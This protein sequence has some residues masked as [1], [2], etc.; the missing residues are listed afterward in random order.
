MHPVQLAQARIRA[1]ERVLAAIRAQPCR[2]PGVDAE[3]AWLGRA[4]VLVD[5]VAQEEVEV[6]RLGGGVRV[7]RAPARLIVL[8]GR[9]GDPQWAGRRSRRAG[10]RAADRRDAGA[11]LPQ[12]E[13]LRVGPEPPDPGLERVVDA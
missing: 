8:A 2:I 6:E 9:E 11:A 4:A 3:V 1:R 10:A 7:R 5:V 13:V 12:V